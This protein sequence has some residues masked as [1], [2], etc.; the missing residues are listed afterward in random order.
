METLIWMGFLAVVGF[1]VLFW[2]VHALYRKFID[3]QIPRGVNS[4][5]QHIFAGV[6]AGVLTHIALALIV[7][8][9][10]DGRMVANILR[11]AALV[12]AVW[13][14]VLVYH[15]LQRRWVKEEAEK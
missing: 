3:P 12:V 14:G 13:A 10:T 6:V 5:G 1:M 2:T 7:D 8:Q 15:L 11:L 4:R 9:L